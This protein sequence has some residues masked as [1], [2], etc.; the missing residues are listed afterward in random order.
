M[1]GSDVKSIVIHPSSHACAGCGCTDESCRWD[2]ARGK[3]VCGQCRNTAAHGCISKLS[4]VILVQKQLGT[5]LDQMP[6]PK[7]MQP[8]FNKV[9]NLAFQVVTQAHREGLLSV[10]RKHFGPGTKPQFK[11]VP[12]E[13]HRLITRLS[14]RPSE[15]MGLVQRYGNGSNRSV[16]K[17]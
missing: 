2:Y 12:A 6:E 9:Q 13:V 11:C 5:M 1:S 10:S 8:G 4:A 14:S 7:I 16:V 3:H 17:E 15:M